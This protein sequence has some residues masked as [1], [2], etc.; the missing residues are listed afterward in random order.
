MITL[1][2]EDMEKL[3]AIAE[4]IEGSIYPDYSGRGM[5]GEK[6]VGITTD[7]S[8]DLL[9]LG[10]ELAETFGDKAR[11]IARRASWDSMGLGQIVYFRGVQA[12][13]GW[14][15]EE[16]A[17]DDWCEGNNCEKEDCHRCFPQDDCTK[18]RKC[19]EAYL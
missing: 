12:P 5:F 13:E 18:H 19:E 16:E 8:A 11:D 1:S 14:N 17:G 9:T 7:G 6:C 4:N 10:I 3:E 15:K 2:F